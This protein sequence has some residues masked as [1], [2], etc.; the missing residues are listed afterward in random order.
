MLLLERKRTLKIDWIVEDNHPKHLKEFL[1]YQGVSRKIIGKVK[2]HGG[3]FLLNHEPVRVTREIKEGDLI[4]M[5][6]PQEAGNENLITSSGDLNILFE[7]DHYLIINKPAGVISVP[8]PAHRGETMASRVKG[9]LTERNYLH[10]TVHVVTRLDRDTS[11]AMIFAKHTFAHSLLDRYLQNKNLDKYYYALVGGH[12]KNKQGI[13]D[14][15]IG[16]HPNSIIE[17]MVA[18]EGK[19][20]QTSYQVIEEYKEMSLI[21]IKLLTGRTHQIRVHFSHLGHPLIGDDLYGDS[22]LSLPR[23]ALHCHQ[24][25]FD[26]PLTKEKLTLH[27]PLPKDIQ[28][29]IERKRGEE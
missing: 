14:A 7:D 2:F 4:S 16:R 1:K 21:R 5:V 8:S 6:L 13:I 11:G 12:L 24:I 27:A 9:Y 19:P 25:S 22:I 18:N 15:P 10:R 29:L 23:Q 26:H 20:A 28:R 3:K 17:R